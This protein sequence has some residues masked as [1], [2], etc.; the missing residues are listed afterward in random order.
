MVQPYI[1]GLLCPIFYAV[2]KMINLFTS[3]ASC[4]GPDVLTFLGFPE[5]P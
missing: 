3:E 5:P 4:K 1:C 2:N